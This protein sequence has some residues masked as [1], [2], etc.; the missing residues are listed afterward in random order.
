MDNALPHSSDA[1]AAL[2]G[3]GPPLIGRWL[4]AGWPLIDG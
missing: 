4:A 1:R 3:G 2:G